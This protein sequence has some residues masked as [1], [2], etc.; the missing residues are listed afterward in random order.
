MQPDNVVAPLPEAAPHVPALNVPPVIE[1][2][3]LEVM[4]APKLSLR[5]IGSDV[6][7]LVI[8]IEIV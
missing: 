8:A 5:T 4:P 7:P 2:G 6:G 1:T 3:P